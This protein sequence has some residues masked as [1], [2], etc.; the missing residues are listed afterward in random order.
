MILLVHGW[1]YGATVWD[2][3][4]R[5]LAGLP[6]ARIDLGF[7][8]APARL[9]DVL[10]GEVPLIGVGHSLG[11]LWLLRHVPN[12]RALLSVNGFARFTED[13]N[14]RGVPA[15]ALTGMRRGFARDP[16]TALTRFWQDCGAAPDI[17]MRTADRAALVQGL[18][19]LRDWDER[20]ALAEAPRVCALASRNDSIVPPDM[21]EAAFAGRDIAWSGSAGHSM[22]LTEPLPVADAILRL[23]QDVR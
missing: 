5:Q 21:A 14:Y 7:F 20:A 13:T 12:C 3:V 6:V 17:D 9:E 11:F 18:D 15:A 4:C 10:R 19:W 1:G 22:P 23:W 2:G 16:E 8:G